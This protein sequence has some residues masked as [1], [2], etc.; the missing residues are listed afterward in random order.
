MSVKGCGAQPATKLDNT[1]IHLCQPTC[2]YQI[3][4]GKNVQNQD[5]LKLGFSSWIKAWF[6]SPYWPEIIQN[7]QLVV[8]LSTSVDGPACLPN[9]KWA[10][11]HVFVC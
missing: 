8:I 9:L 10:K 6:A 2:S 7:T 1:Q 4:R 3:L 5:K 11:T